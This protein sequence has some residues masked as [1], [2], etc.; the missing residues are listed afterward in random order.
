ML[1]YTGE[2]KIRVFLPY[3]DIYPNGKWIEREK[4]CER[5]TCGGFLYEVARVANV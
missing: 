3:C 5:I 2:G 4:T 1:S